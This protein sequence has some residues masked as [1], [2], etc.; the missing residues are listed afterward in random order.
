M[1]ITLSSFFNNKCTST[2]ALLGLVFFLT[3][4][5]TFDRDYEAALNRPHAVDSPEGP[6]SGRWTSTRNGHTGELRC[7]VQKSVDDTYT[8][9][10]KA[11]FWKCFTYTSTADLTMTHVDGEHTFAGNAELGWLAGGRYEYEGRVNRKFF[12]SEYENKW[13]HGTFYMERPKTDF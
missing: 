2:L 4:C 7:I 13:D 3:G 10:F 9:R 11:R 5:S 1:K 8:A 6:W 12:F